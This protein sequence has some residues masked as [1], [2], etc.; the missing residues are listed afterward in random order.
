VENETY[1]RLPAPLI[2]VPKILQSGLGAVRSLGIGTTASVAVTDS[3]MLVLPALFVA[4]VAGLK[5]M[6]DTLIDLTEPIYP[7]S[8]ETTRTPAQW[9][10]PVLTWR[11]TFP[12]TDSV[13]RAA[14][15]VANPA[16]EPPRP[17]P[18][19]GNAP[20]N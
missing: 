11:N 14:N 2:G 15:A 1:F 12:A 7:I 20:R 5:V 19:A 16:P 6:L 18:G 8:D 4:V 3:T 10:K 17:E 9:P 13:D